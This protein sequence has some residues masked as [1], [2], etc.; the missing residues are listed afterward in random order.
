MAT[1]LNCGN[2]GGVLEI[3]PEKPTVECSFCGS[4]FSVS[5]LLNESEQ[6]KLARIRRDVELGRQNL[7]L[8]RIRQAEAET[9]R[10][11]SAKVGVIGKIAIVLAVISILM[12]TS[13]FLQGAFLTGTIA[14]VQFM[15]FL[16]TFLICKQVIPV[17]NKKI[18]ILLFTLALL[19]EIPF[20]L[21]VASSE[22]FNPPNSNEIIVWD[23]IVLSDRIPTLD[24]TSG[25]VS[26][27]TRKELMMI[28][29][30]VPLKQYYDFVE[31]CKKLGFT[32]IS[33]EDDNTY[34]ATAG[35]GYSIRLHYSVLHDG[36]VDVDLFAP[37]EGK[38]SS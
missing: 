37:T 18:H 3:D 15:L 34:H 32:N 24:Q 2:C 19:L 27:N 10:T 5:D 26:K 7:E 9:Q 29:Y 38:S 33:K 23:E 31:D 1:Q 28:V 11:E 36:T 8:A 20:S 12:C 13:A 14:A 30:N 22:V 21:S 35:D 17:K 6:L 4:R 25:Y 16:V